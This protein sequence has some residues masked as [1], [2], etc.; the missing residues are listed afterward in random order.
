MICILNVRVKANCHTHVF[1]HYGET[2]EK[3]GFMWRWVS[4]TEPRNNEMSL[5]V[6]HTSDTQHRLGY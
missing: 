1:L 4:E 5:R 2:S 3:L 6:R